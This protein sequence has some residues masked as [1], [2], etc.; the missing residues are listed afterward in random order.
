MK[1]R[2]RS[3]A[4]LS[5]L[6]IRHYCELWCRSKMRLGSRV[7]VA[8]MYAGSCSSNS[9]PSLGTS[10]CQGR[11]PRKGKKTTT[12]KKKKKEKE[13]PDT[14]CLQVML[15]SMLNRSFA[16]GNGLALIFSFRFFGGF[17]FLNQPHFIISIQQFERTAVACSVVNLF[18]ENFSFFPQHAC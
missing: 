18:I 5:R 16:P 13:K 15:M 11:G 4:S 17:I 9:I 10:I 14:V 8:V 1:L 3:L 7:A 12:T 6:R 2:V